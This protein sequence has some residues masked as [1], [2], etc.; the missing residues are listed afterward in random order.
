[1]AAGK[2][3]YFCC[4]YDN[5]AKGSHS[6]CYSLTG[7]PPFG[8]IICTSSASSP[9]VPW[10]I[11]SIQLSPMWPDY[12]LACSLPPPTTPEGMMTNTRHCADKCPDQSALSSTT[13]VPRYFDP[14]LQCTA[15][16]FTA[17]HCIKLHCTAL[18]CPALNF[19]ALQCTWEGL[20]C[21]ADH[22]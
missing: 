21:W 15:L 19:T 13:V 16:K 8:L 1:M 11:S 20:S 10:L 2:N 12:P 18:H 7:A 6:G 3:I 14:T 17:L 4:W 9:A 5:H 22:C